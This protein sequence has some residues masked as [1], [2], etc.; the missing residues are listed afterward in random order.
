MNIAPPPDYLP[1]Y[2]VFITQPTVE[3]IDLSWMCGVGERTSLPV[4]KKEDKTAFVERM[5]NR[6]NRIYCDIN[7]LMRTSEASAA[8][9]GD[10]ASSGYGVEIYVDIA[11]RAMELRGDKCL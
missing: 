4:L 10:V 8:I 5:A 2:A 1:C 6:Y 11:N 9:S 7:N 3:Y